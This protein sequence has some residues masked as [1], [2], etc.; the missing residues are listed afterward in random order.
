MYGQH[1]LIGLAGPELTPEDVSLLQKVHPA[2]V[3]LFTRNIVS[4]QQTRKLTDDLRDLFEDDF[5]IAIDQEGG[6]VTRTKDMAPAG[7]GARQLRKSGKTHHA[8]QHG[9]LTGSML[10][11]LGINLNFAPVLDI[12]FDDSLFSSLPERCYGEDSQEVINHAGMFNRWMRKH[13]VLSC[14]KHFPSC[15]HAAV[16]PHHDLPKSAATQNQMLASD[17]LPY[18]ALM[19]ELD[20]LMTCHV[21]FSELDPQEPGL[22]ASLSKN[23]VTHLLREQLGFDRHLVFTDDLDMGAII[24]TYGRGEDLKRAILAGNDIGLIC[25]ETHTAIDA[26]E[27]LRNLPQALLDDT[28]KRIKRFKK[29]MKYPPKFDTNRWNTICGEIEELNSHFE[30]EENTGFSQVTEF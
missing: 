4:P 7:P 23:I 11:Q 28:E 25:H 8:A 27:H 2:G 29:K 13:K 20:S 14:G 19:P 16:D 18:T 1:L 26:I 5:I 10:A 15:S 21:H 12:A 30:A 6:R 24:N 9:H 22:P 3:I 17:L